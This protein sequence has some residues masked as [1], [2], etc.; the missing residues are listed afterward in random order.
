MHYVQQL[1]QNQRRYADAKIEAAEIFNQWMNDREKRIALEKDNPLQYG[2]EPPIW[3]IVDG[4]WNAPWTDADMNRKIRECL[5]FDRRIRFIMILGGNRGTKTDYTCKRAVQFMAHTNKARVWMFQLNRQMSIEV[6]HERVYKYLPPLWRAKRSG[7]LNYNDKS[8]FTQDKAVLQNKSIITFKSYAMDMRD[9]V[10]G[11]EQDLIVEDE[12]SPLEWHLTLM[13]RVSTRGGVIFNSFTPVDGYTPLVAHYMDGAVPAINSTAYLLPDDG[14][15]PDFAR[16]LGFD[17][18]AEMMHQHARGIPCRP[19]NCMAW[20]DGKSGQPAPPE[21]RTFQQVPR[22]MRCPG[23]PDHAIVYFHSMDNPFAFPCTDPTDGSHAY[24]RELEGDVRLSVARVKERIYGIPLRAVSGTFPSFDAIHIMKDKD[25][26]KQGTN[27]LIVDPAKGRNFAMIWVRKTKDNL[28]VY[29]EWPGHYVVPGHGVP[30][31]WA[32]PS[33]RKKGINDGDPGPGQDPLGFGLTDYKREIARLEGWADYKRWAAGA[34][35]LEDHPI[36]EWD[37]QNEY[38]ACTTDETVYDRFLD[39]R[40]ATEPRVENDRPTTLQSEFAEQLGLDFGLTPGTRT[41]DG[42]ALIN[43]ALRYDKDRPVSYLN[44]P[45]VYLAESCKNM[46]YCLS[47]YL[48]VDGEKGAS[49]DF[50]DLLRYAL[51]LDLEYVDVSNALTHWPQGEVQ[52][53]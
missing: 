19:Q 9:A 12:L 41:L 38:D 16:A 24:M 47:A 43:E 45:K 25:I 51:E 6:H 7:A 8:G 53:W 37:P 21:G 32:I 30:G 34:V 22:I 20:L 49:K 13:K 28:Y 36:S 33:S 17:S 2:Y 52:V 46:A 31:A 1:P 10:E 27:Y 18:E 14:G 15:P 39:S 42:I 44:S 48:N 26:P 40:A 50:I 4:L 3:R 29:R 11:A 23:K 5:G 35:S